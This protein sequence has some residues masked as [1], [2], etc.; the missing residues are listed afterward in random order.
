MLVTQLHTHTLFCIPVCSGGFATG[1][2]A[3]GERERADERG[4]ERESRAHKHANHT[5][6][7]TAETQG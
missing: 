5:T 3:G 2:E 6:A 7:K 4:R 1:T